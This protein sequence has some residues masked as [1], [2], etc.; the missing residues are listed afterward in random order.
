MIGVTCKPAL[1]CLALTEQPFGSACAFALQFGP[2]LPVPV[3]DTLYMSTRVDVAFAVN[4]YVRNTRDVELTPP[5][6]CSSP[7]ACGLRG[8]EEV[9]EAGLG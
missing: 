2:E 6:T 8:A 7:P 3:A 4:S 9:G 5:L 1:F